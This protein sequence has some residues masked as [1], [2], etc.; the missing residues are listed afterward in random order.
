M[1][2]SKGKL[3]IHVSTDF[4]NSTKKSQ[5]MDCAI[6]KYKYKLIMV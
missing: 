4:V 5:L 3:L 2:L 1:Y 6:Y